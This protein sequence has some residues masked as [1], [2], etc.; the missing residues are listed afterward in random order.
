[1]IGEQ[2]RLAIW[3]AGP[4]CENQLQVPTGL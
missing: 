3:L 4:V 1:M 2:A